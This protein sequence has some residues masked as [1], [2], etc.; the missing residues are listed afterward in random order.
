MGWTCGGCVRDECRNEEVEEKKALLVVVFF[1]EARALPV[2]G[3][4][5]RMR[6]LEDQKEKTEKDEL[7][8]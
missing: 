5:S 1:R 7:E 6:A 2:V 8:V 3:Y 4:F